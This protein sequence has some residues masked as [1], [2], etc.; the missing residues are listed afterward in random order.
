MGSW[1]ACALAWLRRHMTQPLVAA[2]RGQ[3]SLRAILPPS[4]FACFAQPVCEILLA[5][6]GASGS[7]DLQHRFSIFSRLA[8]V[9]GVRCAEGQ[10]IPASPII[11]QSLQ[12]ALPY[13][14][15]CLGPIRHPL[16]GIEVW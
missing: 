4:A 13:I 12:G 10:P 9:E 1:G 7:C 14:Y 2:G 3:L 6:G 8:E 16:R 11:N 15:A 5:R